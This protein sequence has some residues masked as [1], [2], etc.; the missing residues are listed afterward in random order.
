MTDNQPTIKDL[1]LA[2]AAAQATA[3]KEAD[4][5]RLHNNRRTK[6]Y[7]RHVKAQKRVNEIRRQIKALRRET[8]K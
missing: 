3:K 8:S 4:N 1:E 5:M 7:H 6:A 2:L